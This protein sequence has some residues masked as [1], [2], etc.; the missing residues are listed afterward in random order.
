MFII[1]VASRFTRVTPR[2]EL[3]GPK[4]VQSSCGRQNFAGSNICANKLCPLWLARL[5]DIFG[6]TDTSFGGGTL[7]HTL[8]TTILADVLAIL[9]FATSELVAALTSNTTSEFGVSDKMS[10]LIG[11]ALKLAP[12]DCASENADM[13]KAE[14]HF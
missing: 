6:A 11:P 8:K 9:T 2:K 14:K 10:R 3:H 4:N 12:G 7:V 5:L 13:F 1:F